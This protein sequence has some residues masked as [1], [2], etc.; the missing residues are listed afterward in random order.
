VSRAAGTL[1]V[2]VGLLED[3]RGRVLVNR[4]RPGTHMAGFWEFPGGKRAPGEE[5]LD[6]LRRELHEELG[7]MLLEAAP[8]IELVHDYAERR[9]RLDVWLVERYE[10]EPSA[11]EQQELRWLAPE[12]L[13]LIDL[14]PA[15]RPIVD[16]LLARSHTCR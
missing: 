4:R 6:A 3:A 16:A 13:A 14:L 15:D 12:E 7:V 11:L 5:R 9:V 1:H 2:L 10:G 8:F